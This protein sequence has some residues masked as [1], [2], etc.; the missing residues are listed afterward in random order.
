[1]A[2]MAERLVPLPLDFTITEVM[3]FWA[4][5][6][7][8]G[9]DDCWPWLGYCRER[10]DT[11]GSVIDRRGRV[12]LRGQVYYAC[13]VAYLYEHRVDPGHYEVCHTCHNP[14]CVNPRHLVLGTHSDNMQHKY[15]AGR[16]PYG[17]RHS[18]TLLTDADVLEIRRRYRSGETQ[19]SIARSFQI[20]R[21][22]IQHIVDRRTWQ[23]LGG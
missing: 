2:T 11:Y 6:D 3:R 18:R 20:S 1:M 5:T 15:E 21:S 14:V 4:L 23:H 9:P 7:R 13:R 10:T 19:H 8:R 17:D 12:M 16:H 22:A